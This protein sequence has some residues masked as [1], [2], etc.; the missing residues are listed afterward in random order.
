MRKLYIY[1][2]FL[3]VFAAGLILWGVTSAR[4]TAERVAYFKTPERNRLLI[5]AAAIPTDPAAAR[6]ILD[7]APWTDGQLTAAYLYPS[8]GAEIARLSLAVGPPSILAAS[9]A[10]EIAAPDFSCR[11]TISPA[12]VKVWTGNCGAG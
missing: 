5:Y 6:S 2:G 11:L 7:R 1:T 9:A 3:L 8:A 4:N 10:V 12:G